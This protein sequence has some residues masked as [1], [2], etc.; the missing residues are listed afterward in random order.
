MIR[1][2]HLTK[3]YG[4]RVAVDDLCFE[5][6]AGE[7]VA[8]LGPNG[9]GKSTTMRILSGFLPPSGGR[10][11]VAGYD[12]LHDSLQVRR[13]IGYMPENVP[14]YPEMRVAE[15]LAFRARLRGVARRALRQHLDEAIGVCGLTD[16][17]GRI[18]GQLSKGFRQ[19]VGL[20]DALVHKP[21]LLI[22]D[23]PSIGLDPNQMR[24]IRELIRS[25]G[26]R[27]TVLLST[28]ILSEVESLCE[29]VL[30]L[31]HGRI[32]AADT[33][34]GLAGLVAGHTRVRAELRG[35]REDVVTALRSLPGVLAVEA[36]PADGEWLRA[37]CE[38]ERGTDLRERIFDL[39]RE[40]G[41]GLRAIASEE[42]NLE[43]V[44]ASVT[45]PK[46]KP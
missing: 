37:C 39:A 32:V 27:H 10:V 18:I 1:V 7:I 4:G 24:Q 36:V 42:A 3:L 46:E 9:A 33:P 21:A 13:R 41:W 40:R 16:V 12:V 8:F 20:A 44:F 5:V 30:I 28:H 31:H 2:E 45:A 38:C 23:E 11:T 17:A 35:P 29:R 26:G 15:Y 25:L 22:L 34:A 14:L 43:D 19:R 6:A